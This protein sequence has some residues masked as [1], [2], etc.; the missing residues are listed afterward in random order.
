M[1]KK[2]LISFLLCGEM[3]MIIKFSFFKVKRNAGKCI[4][5]HSVFAE[6]ASVHTDHPSH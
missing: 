2:F 3:D 6:S 5:E 4:C 1:H